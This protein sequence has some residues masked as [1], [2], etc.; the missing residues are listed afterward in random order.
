[1]CGAKAAHV[2][3]DERFGG[4]L[5][6]V[7]ELF[8]EPSAKLRD[9]FSLAFGK[10]LREGFAEGEHLDGVL[11]DARLGVGIGVS[12]VCDRGVG[13]VKGDV[14]LEVVDRIKAKL[15]DGSNAFVYL[16]EA[17]FDSGFEFLSEPLIEGEV[18][19]GAWSFWDVRVIGKKESGVRKAFDADFEDT[20]LLAHRGSIVEGVAKELQC[21][22]DA[23]KMWFDGR[24]EPMLPID[25]RRFRGSLRVGGERGSGWILGVGSGG[26]GGSGGSGGSGV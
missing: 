26:N 1:M 15:Q 19:N 14:L 4:C 23:V 10:L 21:I 25:N 9:A 20:P 17:K 22:A 6:E 13:E 18:D 12:Q 11:I 3:F 7:G 16:T 24:E 8:G 5:V 2:A